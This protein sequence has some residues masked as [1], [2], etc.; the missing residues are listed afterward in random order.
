MTRGRRWGLPRSA[1]PRSIARSWTGWSPSGL[2]ERWSST[3]RTSASTVPP[4]ARPSS[5]QRSAARRNGDGFE[6]NHLNV[7]A[8]F[9][10]VLEDKAL[11]LCAVLREKT[12]SRNLIIAGGVALNSVMNGRIVRE[13]GFDDIYVMPAAGDNG[14]AIGAAMYVYNVVLG[15]PRVS[16]HDDPYLGTSYSDEYI[17]RRD[18]RRK[19]RRRATRR[20]RVDRGTPAGRR[21]DRGLVP[22]SDG[23]RSAGA[24]QSQ[25]PGEPD[26]PRHEGQG[27]RRGQASRGL[28]S[29]RAVGAGRGHGHVLRRDRR[30]PVH[31]Q[32][33]SGATR[34]VRPVC[35]LSRTST[36][37]R[38][39]T[40]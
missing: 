12:Q 38:V 2:T 24:R 7:A 34:D 27:E 25:H 31:A 6:A 15:Q 13:A 10:A 18:P 21:P 39:C 33:L 37:R 9:Q 23:D 35:P 26:A 4:G 29:V 30:E 11:E 20:H 14:T 16:V 36:A 3:R 32:G 28:P 40:P 1:T 5:P 22:G 17:E 19:A 8:A